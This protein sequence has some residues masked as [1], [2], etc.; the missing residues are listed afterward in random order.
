MNR[1]IDKNTLRLPD[2]FTHITK[3]IK[4]NKQKYYNEINSLSASNPKNMWS[5]IKK[6]V[7]NKS[8]SNPVNCDIS[9]DRFKRDISLI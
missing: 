2:K 9:P 4:E 3:I 5:E 7:S 8:R 6:L 1:H